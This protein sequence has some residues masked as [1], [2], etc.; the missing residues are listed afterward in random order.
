MENILDFWL[1]F[2]YQKEFIYLL[3]YHLVFGSLQLLFLYTIPSS[4][5][6]FDVTQ[7]N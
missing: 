3:V 4:L 2:L 5:L 1:E 7:G 6:I